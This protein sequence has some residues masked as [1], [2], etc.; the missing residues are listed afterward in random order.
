MINNAGYAANNAV[1]KGQTERRMLRHEKQWGR[2]HLIPLLQAETDRDLVRR[3]VD[4]C[5]ALLKVP[6]KGL[7]ADGRFAE[8]ESNPVYHCERYVEP[9]FVIPD[10]VISAQWW[11]GSKVFTKNPPYQERADFTREAPIG[12]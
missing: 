12:Q 11:R 3:G 7:G 2:I 10:N 9:V 1:A 4:T 8:G 5:A 6:T